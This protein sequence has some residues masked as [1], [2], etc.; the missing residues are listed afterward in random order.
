MTYDHSP[1]S[2]W[3]PPLE[4]WSKLPHDLINLMPHM[5]CAELK[6]TLY[7]LRH[8]WG[9]GN[10]TSF[11]PMTIDEI[12]YGRHSKNGRIDNGT[13]LSK[14]SV[15]TGIAQ[16]I[17]RGTLVEIVDS[18]DKAR[19]RKFYKLRGQETGQPMS[20][21]ETADVQ[22][23]DIDL[24]KDISK[25]K[26]KERKQTIRA[27][28]NEALEKTFSSCTGIRLPKRDTVAQRRSA[29]RL[30]N[31]PLWNIYDLFMPEGESE[32]VYD[33]DTLLQAERLIQSAVVR[34]REDK[35]TIA[36][37]ASIEKVAISMFAEVGGV[38][39]ETSNNFWDQYR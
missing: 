27:K 10:Y 19:I 25:D 33:E 9:Y 14:Q 2:G 34:M 21:K 4:N 31:T 35:L 6:V 37:P 20:K 24:N 30:W 11:V 7:I 8:T 13:G 28:Y 26:K 1:F 3:A 16:G 12:R 36:S 15:I 39:A 23:L 32:N 38:A 22:N 5:N 18:S 29:G 17:K